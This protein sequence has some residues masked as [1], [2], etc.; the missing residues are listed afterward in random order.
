MTWAQY[1]LDNHPSRE[2]FDMLAGVLILS[3][4]WL[5]FLGASKL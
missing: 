1:L 4:M 5:L 3:A 2:T